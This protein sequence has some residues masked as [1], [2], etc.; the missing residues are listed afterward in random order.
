MRKRIE[1]VRRAIR[2]RTADALG[3]ARNVALLNYPD[4]WNVGDSALW[5]GAMRLFDELGVNVVYHA[6]HLNLDPDALH[7]MSDLDAIVFTGGGNF[8]D[9]WPG[10]HLP[11]ERVLDEFRDVP[12]VQLPQ[13]LHFDQVENLE[14]TARL[15]SGVQ[16]LTLMWRDRPS[17]AEAQK[18]IAARHILC[19]DNAY[20]LGPFPPGRPEIEVAWLARTDKES[21]SSPFALELPDNVVVVDWD[22]PIFPQPE[23]EDLRR[24]AKELFAT[25]PVDYKSIELVYRC[26]AELRVHRGLRILSYGRFVI[27]DRLHADIMLSLQ[28]RPHA[29][30]DNS[31]GKVSANWEY[32]TRRWGL[33]QFAE[34]VGEA[35]G[36][37]QRA[38]S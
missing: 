28:G 18:T 19:P 32:V 9:L 37:A 27:T 16:N 5:L 31:Y 29:L 7:S 15:A 8:G 3:D 4:Y 22:S 25:T 14:R 20:M 35:L 33:A 24:R 21:T 30:L 11:R 12:I 1:R 23:L 17:Y 34:S 2:R 10:A 13:S 36:I 26:I 6:T 38:A